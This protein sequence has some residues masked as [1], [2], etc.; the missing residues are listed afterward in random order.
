M[1][2]KNNGK[3]KIWFDEKK[4]KNIQDELSSQNWFF[5]AT[6]VGA[7]TY[8]LKNHV[9]SEW[10]NSND[11]LKSFC[12]YFSKILRTHLLKEEETFDSTTKKKCK[13]Y[14]WL[15]NPFNDVNFCNAMFSLL[16]EDKN[17]LASNCVLLLEQICF[18]SL[19]YAKN[20]HRLY[21]A[22]SDSMGLFFTDRYSYIPKP[23][24]KF[25]DFLCTNIKSVDNIKKYYNKFKCKEDFDKNYASEECNFLISYLSLFLYPKFRLLF[26]CKKDGFEFVE[27]AM[28][29]YERMYNNFIKSNESYMDNEGAIYL[30]FDV[31]SRSF[32][33]NIIYAYRNDKDTSIKYKHIIYLIYRFYLII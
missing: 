13:S 33:K 27:R 1:E 12:F 8:C 11:E 7:L 17:N 21:S 25:M 14:H 20:I 23:S 5:S 29:L 32:I 15:G 4:L 24:I 6:R 10:I 16:G 2:I 30:F 22:V 31:F 26:Q 18:T 28:D 19:D 9:K 3:K